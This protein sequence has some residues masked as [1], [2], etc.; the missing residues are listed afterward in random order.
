MEYTRQVH[1][2]ELLNEPSSSHNH[3][4]ID[5]PQPTRGSGS[6]NDLDREKDR[7][8]SR[9]AELDAEVELCKADMIEIKSRMEMRLQEKEMLERQLVQSRLIVDIKGKGKARQGID[10]MTEPFDWSGGLKAR[11]K[12]VFGIQ[13]FRLCQ[14]GWVVS[15]PSPRL[16]LSYFKIEF[17]MPTWTVV[18]L[19]VLCPQVRCSSLA[20]LFAENYSGG[21][22]S[23]TYQLPAIITPGCTLV[24]SPLISLMTDQILHLR[25]AESLYFEFSCFLCSNLFYTVEAVMITGTTSKQE[26]TDIVRRLHALAEKRVGEEGSE[27]KLCYVTVSPLYSCDQQTTQLIALVQPEKMSKD[28]SFRAMLQKLD[29]AKKFGALSSSQPSFH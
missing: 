3:A 23:L 7:I 28:A 4:T 15:G 1:E 12:A 25:E 22:K 29:N 26:R 11:M 6:N 16:S 19:S 20:A 5:Q 10:Y 2:V 17:V 13:S 9:I 18:T 27:I 24:I 14:E 8:I 21:G